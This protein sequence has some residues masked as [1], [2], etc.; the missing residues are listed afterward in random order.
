M[1]PCSAHNGVRNLL[2]VICWLMSILMPVA[3]VNA[4]PPAVGVVVLPVQQETIADPI[5]ALGTL[6][7]NEAISVTTSVAEIIEKISFDS[8]QRVRRGDVLA[9]LESTEEQAVLQ[10]ARHTLNEAKSQL[11][12]I[13]ALAR[14]GDASQSN[15][16]EQQ[17]VYNVAKA[18]VAAI[19]ARLQYR[20]ISAPF[21]GR[22]GLRN[23]SPGAFVSPGDVITTLVD[24][25]RMKLDFNVPSLFIRSLKPGVTIKAR[26]RALG[27]E[28]FSGVVDAVD[29][30]VDPVSRSVTVRALLDNPQGVLKP[31]LMMEVQLQ[32]NPRNALLVP[33][34]ALT[35]QGEEHFVFVARDSEEG[36]KAF[37]QTIKTGVRLRGRVEVLAGLQA[38]DQV[39]VDGS[40]K[41]QSGVLIKALAQS[42]AVSAA[43]PA[44]GE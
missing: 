6:K 7:A 12:R 35:Q 34:S 42:P 26:A 36:L 25:S 29:N 38:G 11:E 8:G 30:Q 27:D 19:E 40:L 14:R 31:G 1:L 16:D 5:E 43:V 21:S 13:R 10:E 20:T 9:V 39:V 37:R 4:A 22:V 24:D 2:F 23:V 15:L 18:R 32:S 3:L 17:R 41:L 44:L 28:E 33:E